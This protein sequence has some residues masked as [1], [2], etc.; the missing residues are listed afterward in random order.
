MTVLHVS[1]MQF[2]EHHRFAG[3]GLSEALLKDLANLGK[4][5]K[6]SPGIVPDIVVVAGD[7]TEAA[8]PSEYEM[9]HDFLVALRDGLGLSTER[10]VVV[11]GN[12]DVSRALCEAYFLGQKGRGK[13]PEPPYWPKWEAYIEFHQRLYGSDFPKDEPWTYVE[14]PDLGVAV[15]GL[16]ST[17]ADSHRQE[18]Q[19]GYLGDRQL[20]Y[21]AGRMK[22]VQDRGW[23]RL[24]VI[25]HN[26]IRGTG[27][28]DAYVHDSPRFETLLA[29]HLDLVLHGHTHDARV[30]SFGGIAL[31]VLGSGSAGVTAARRPPEV[32]NQYQ[33]VQLSTARTRVW[34]RRY[35]P[36]QQHWVGDSSISENH[37]DWWRDLP[38]V[39][40]RRRPVRNPRARK[41][42]TPDLDDLS[43]GSQRRPDDLLARVREVC[44]IR[45]PGATI[46]DVEGYLRVTVNRALSPDAL[47]IIE[48]YPIGVCEGPA[49]PEDVE[50]FARVDALYRSSGPA[51]G[52]KLIYGGAPAE[53]KLRESAALQG[54]EL[55]SFTEYQT[56]YD[57]R[58][59]GKRQAEELA[60]DA[61]YPPWLYV[62]QRYLEVGD[63]SEPR[64]D[65]LSRL[66]TW[67]A[68]PSGHLVAV[69]AP[70]G[71]GKTFLLRELARRMHE[72]RD[73]AVPVLVHLRDLEKVHK[74]D[75]LVASQLAKGG[76]RRI[77]LAMFDYLLREGRIALL[78]DG[79]D[80]L[81]VRVT[82][83]R[84]AE[85]LATIVQAAAGRAKVVFTSRD[86]HFL[87]DND[88]LSALGNRLATASG[89]RLIKL[90]PFD[91]DQI[92]AFLTKRLG[93]QTQAQQRMQLL[94]NVRDLLGLSRN[95]RMLDFIAQITA[96]RLIAAQD[97]TGEI[98]A[99]ALYRELLG[100]W[101]EYERKRLDRPGGPPPP[102]ADQL[103]R[104]VTFL[105][106]RLWSSGAAELGVIDL[107]GADLSVADLGLD[108]LEA[109]A[110]A[111]ATMTPERMTPERMAPERDDAS[112]ADR[113]QASHMIGSATLLVRDGDGRFTFVHRSIMEW[114]VARHTADQLL[115]GDELPE[116][117]RRP[118]SELMTDFLCDLA[119]R[120]TA[121]IWANQI[122]QRAMTGPISDNA[123]LV[124]RRLG[125]EATATIHFPGR[126]LLGR[127]F[128]G[129]KMPGADL[130]GADLTETQFIGTDLTGANL[131]GARIVNA[132]FDRAQMPGA[133]LRDANLSGTSLIGADLSDADLTGA[134]MRRVALTGATV[135]PAALATAD[136]LFGAAVPD[137][138]PPLPQIAGTS[139]TI[140]AVAYGPA[141][142]ILAT[143]GGD[144]TVWLWNPTTGDQLRQ[145]TGHTDDVLSVAFSP[146]GLTLA[147]GDEGGMVRLWNPTTGQQVHQ[148]AG[149][150][151]R[152]LSVA[153]SPD[154]RA[155]AT[156]GDDG[157]VRLWNPT[158]GDPIRQLTGHTDYVSVAFS[159][160]G[161]ALATGS[162]DGTA[163]LWNPITGEQ[164]SQLT[165]HISRVWSVAFSPDGRYLA[166]GS[167]DGTVR[168]WDPATGDPIH[169]LTGHTGGVRSVAFS[170]DGIYLATGSDDG[171]VRLWDPATGDPIRQLTGHTSR[172]L[173]VA[174]SPDGH[175]LATG[176]DDGTVRLWNLITGEQ[177]RQ[178][179]GYISRVTSVAFSPDGK[180]LA[181][182]SFDSAGR[183][184]NPTTIQQVDQ[185]S[186]YV[187]S[188]AFSPDG[189]YLATGSFDGTVRLWNPTTGERI[190]QL[191]GHTR[192]VLSVAFSPDG[193]HL[194]TGGDDG[195]VRLWNPVTGEQIHQLTSHISRVWSVAFS[196][197]GNLLATGGDDGTVRLWNPTT[198]E[199]IH[200]LTSHASRVLSVAFSPDGSV[201]A[202]G[203]DDGKVRLWNPTGSQIHQLTG[204]T[205][206][207]LSVAFSPDGSVLAT[208]SRDGTVWLWD[209][210][211]YQQV[212]EMAGHTN[213]VWSVA[214]SPDGSVLATGSD[215][216]TVRLWNPSTGDQMA[217]LVPLRSGGWAALGPDL[218]YKVEGVVN[219]EFWYAIGLCRFEPGELDEYVPGLERLEPDV[220]FTAAT[221]VAGD[222]VPAS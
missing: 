186:D 136:D 108:D 9:V 182:G 3:S 126:G 169:R 63:R 175:H 52:S 50:R 96:E 145:L 125:L 55:L 42:G 48:T 193:H 170:P 153:F 84:A 139:A 212:H 202:T 178:L 129:W 1:D 44:G 174:F 114:L 99:A 211:T 163:R 196:P 206:R 157:T 33:L 8:M 46:T 161:R 30:Q 61:I 164:M 142:D 204:R 185:F 183:L 106:L 189:L 162:F 208:G 147:A 6:K 127:D 159:P 56:G 203:S 205:S 177:I 77:D 217:V 62:P 146:D 10:I 141:G 29:S 66:R 25:H 43:N 216:G 81:A 104:A 36:S 155:L 150:T 168:L 191:I 131:T 41:P 105:A 93:D 94:H 80:E 195:T 28:D 54:I 201:L 137:A 85:H 26:L 135:T 51:I 72:E 215:D 69:L 101:L 165:G 151:G 122:M 37:N 143:G 32:P 213:R 53:A 2:G 144:R 12:H 140:R 98:T 58:P 22:Q 124:L 103:W 149:H 119:G 11:P 117:L 76:E 130:S 47:P 60:S 133:L 70:F 31:P 35:D 207:V 34:A 113:Q 102:D 49:T 38:S 200:Q 86:N 20:Q 82:Y 89:R 59:Y 218:R 188:V 199:Q 198:G 40:K 132:R 68:D 181:T 116:P 171:T 210:V 222:V 120:D 39:R 79:F 90:Q 74:L 21:F 16:N 87:S 57:L 67:L 71:H 110:D 45:L 78:F 19:H 152:V 121:Q 112:T 15:A 167:D 13:E 109:A 192:R 115:A 5:S 128:S 88:V 172:M 18:D 95:P 91:D 184:W 118:M 97:G 158:T 160:D 166:T 65:I 156:G 148:L 197:D 14:L 154:G 92:S 180:R 107:G 100:Q 24:G 83:E 187:W 221:Q 179:T 190:A 27:H 138:G 134:T 173:S 73:P 220:P 17:I 4:S 219:G 176:G 194:A 111:L 64:E 123:L 7:L 214:F 75:E 209:S 23:L